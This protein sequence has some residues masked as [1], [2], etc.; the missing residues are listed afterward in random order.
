VRG[1]EEVDDEFVYA[2]MPF[3]EIGTSGK[4]MDY[5]NLLHTCMPL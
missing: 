1:R 2:R 5:Y 3:A 4:K